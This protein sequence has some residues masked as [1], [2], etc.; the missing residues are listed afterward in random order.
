MTATKRDG[1]F[2]RTILI[3]VDVL[4]AALIFVLPFIMGGRE[5]WGHWFLISASL[6]LGI[7]WCVYA[8]VS[9]A[10]YRISWLEGFILAGLAIAWFQIQPQSADVMQQLSAEYERLLPSWAA[11]Q[12]TEE[13]SAWSTPS[14]TPIETQHAWWVFAAR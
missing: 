13:V 8:T 4:I 1:R 3:A 9:G 2:A 5:A 10:R 11:T 6:A 12:T 7:A 14:F